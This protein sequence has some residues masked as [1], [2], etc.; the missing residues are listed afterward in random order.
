MVGRADVLSGM[1]SLT[2]VL[3][4]MNATS[5]FADL[6]PWRR[7]RARLGLGLALILG[8]A[9]SFAKELGISSL[10]LCI[11]HEIISMLVEPD[12]EPMH[13]SGPDTKSDERLGKGAVRS[14]KK[15]SH[16]QR[17]NRRQCPLLPKGPLNP[18]SA[19]ALAWHRA[20]QHPEAMVRVG[21]CLLTAL[22][23]VVV[24]VA[25]HGEHVR[26]KLVF[27][28]IQLVRSFLLILLGR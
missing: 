13:S 5:R 9:A 10:G 27:V 23:V 25:L 28:D 4:Y 1:L 3:T 14:K 24:H 18:R 7:V 19:V 26:Y 2:T 15:D 20:R 12:E 16:D 6:P 21:L 8:V 17:N 22:A 11:V